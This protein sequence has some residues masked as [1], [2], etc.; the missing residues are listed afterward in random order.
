MPV[1]TDGDRVDAT[2]DETMKTKR[3]TAQ[4]FTCNAASVYLVM[5]GIALLI[6]GTA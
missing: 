6:A 2:R 1:R 5:L 3:K 4:W